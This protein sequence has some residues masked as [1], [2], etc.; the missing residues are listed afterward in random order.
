MAA[1][2][3][4][5]GVMMHA[6]LEYQALLFLLA[7]L[8]SLF[9]L[10][11]VPA[12]KPP[13]LLQLSAACGIV[14]IGVLLVLGVLNLRRPG[15]LWHDEASILSVAAAYLH[16]KPLY[17][18]RDTALYSLLYGPA[19][20]LV[21]VPILKFFAHPLAAIRVLGFASNLASL[22]LLY[23]ILRTHVPRNV[24]LALLP[25]AI[26]SLL[27]STSPLYGVRGDSLLLLC[28]AA[29]LAAA[30]RL[31][32]LPAVLVSGISCGLA[33][34]LK[35]TVLP[36]VCLMFAVLY[37]RHK[38]RAWLI[39]AATTLVAAVTPFLLP[40]I[41]L[42]AY[43]EWLTLSVHQGFL[44]TGFLESLAAAAFLLLPAILLKFTASPRRLLVRHPGLATS[45]LFVIA[46]AFSIAI[47][48][49]DGAGPWHLWPMIP[50][51]I[52][53]TATLVQNAC[54]DAAGNLH[55]ARQTLA[56][57][58]MAAMFVCLRFGYRDLRI[59]HA[60]DIAVQRSREDS[61]QVEIHSLIAHNPG[62]NLAMGYGTDASDP[63]TSERF[64]LPL[65]GED[66]FLD[67]NA[68][69]ESLK[70][71]RAMA[72]SV[73]QRVLSCNDL[74]LIPRGEVPFG[75][76]RRGVLANG[77]SLY[78]F[79]D[80]VRVRFPQQHQRLASGNSYDV[81]GCDR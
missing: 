49:K 33:L 40:N 8:A 53:G 78:L 35:I 14:S 50:F 1:L 18:A 23:S 45:A 9:I 22:A 74:W 6:L 27:L 68:L 19:T 54:G 57:I 34:D 72:P 30:L 62:R 11:S 69:V 42:R 66:Y 16:G 71:G 20:F 26:A 4:T 76:L 41:S 61:A 7:F 15:F 5:I 59:V 79:P 39:C 52:L 31:Q 56:A 55:P 10:R 60:K 63:L 47:S 12:V 64:M 24:A 81:W 25:V 46:L 65:L 77:D 70:A 29:G 13:V 36:V 21:Y 32:W 44:L 2:S 37:Q 58:A 73:V 51:V 38:N 28:F 48:S 43:L 67:E 17:H 80:E 75:T 3:C